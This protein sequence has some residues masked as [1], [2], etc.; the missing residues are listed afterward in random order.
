METKTDLSRFPF[1]SLFCDQYGDPHGA[2]EANGKLVIAPVQSKIF[3]GYLRECAFRFDGSILSSK[4]IESISEQ[5]S[6]LA[7]LG[8]EQRDL[9]L[10]VARGQDGSIFV[11]GLNQV[12]QISSGGW[13]TVNPP[14]MFR[15]TPGMKELSSP[16]AGGD[17]RK[18]L[19]F[20]QLKDP[21]DQLL[22]F[23]FLVTAF[24][25]DIAHPLLSMNG[26]Q[27]SGKS[28]FLRM[29]VRIL[30]PSI[31]EDVHFTSEHDFLIA[32]ANRWLVPLDNISKIKE[33]MS[34]L[35][36]KFVTG[37]SF[38]RRRLYT[39][40]GEY[41]RTF[42]RVVIMNGINSPMYKPDILDR[43]LLINLERIVSTRRR[44]EASI[45][46]DFNS[47]LPEIIGGCFD[48][49]AK[50]QSFLPYIKLESKP[51]LADF[52]IWGCAIARALGYQDADF[53]RAY[54]KNVERQTEEALDASPLASALLCYFRDD[55]RPSP[56]RIL[57][58][59][60]TA[61]LRIIRLV[62]DEAG[63]DEKYLPKSA[64]GLANSLKE[65]QPN[66]ES[67]GFHIERIRGKERTLTIHPPKKTIL[68]SM[69]S[70]ESQESP[71]SISMGAL[72][73]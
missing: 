24:V 40:D 7:Y 19:D 12:Y 34:D 54:S 3:S 21:D 43:S 1:I 58:G 50:A 71:N 48:L 59:T 49:L 31:S 47:V 61:V 33:S 26:P 63:V 39:D 28:T 25:P 36:C 70:L 27:G 56:N 11:D 10:R 29:L 30:D 51:R 20:I 60:P 18:L 46:T 55:R 22:V 13:K 42:R 16:M 23:A 14:I 67:R 73:K 53:I 35:M 6:A 8:K 37:S 15:R 17:V 66:L 68:E 52:A 9:Q 41:I 65:L 45:W 64:R 5:C 62:A 57:T 44:D 69:P 38:S 4:K 2:F 72:L 32:V